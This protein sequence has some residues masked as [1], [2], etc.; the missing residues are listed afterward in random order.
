[1]RGLTQFIGDI[2]N[3][4]NKEDERKR[5]DKEMANI[6]KHFKEATKLTPY[7]KKKYVWKMLY[8]YVLG[9]EVDFGHMEALNLITAPGYSEKTVGYLACV[10]LLSET[11]EF[12]RLII[13]ST[14]N[15]LMSANEEIQGLSLACVA[16]VG[17]REFA[18]TLTVDV[19]K[20]LFNP[21][22]R[23]QVK[24]KAALCMLRLLRKYPDNFAEDGIGGNQEQKDKL[25]DLL[26]DSSLGVITATMSLLLG[27]VSHNPELWPDSVNKCCKLLAK[28]NHPNASKEYGPEYVYYKTINPWL[29]VKVLRLLQYYPPPEREEVNKR[30]CEVLQRIISETSM[31]KNVNTN[32]SAHAVVFEAVN[33]VIH[34]ETNQQLIHA[35]VNMLGQRITSGNQPNYRY[36]ALDAMQRMSHIPEAAQQFKRHQET[37]IRSLKDN[38]VSLRRRSLDVLYSMCDSNNSEQVVGELLD[39]LAGSDFSIREE[40]VLRVAILAE[41]FSPNL[42]WYV[43]TILKLMSL[44]G[45]YVS[46]QVWMRVVQIVTNH[47]D[48][49]LYAAETCFK[50]LKNEAVHESMVKCGGYI[51]GEF[52]HHIASK[53]E[54]SAEEQ[55][56]LLKDKFDS[57][58]QNET[59]QLLLTAFI[60]LV[61]VHPDKV[62]ERVVALLNHHT[63]TIDA[64]LQQRAIEYLVLSR[65]DKESMLETV[66][67]VMPNFPER[68]NILTKKI[69][70][71]ERASTT[72]RTANQIKAGKGGEDDDEDAPT[73]DLSARGK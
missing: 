63:H 38:D 1:M 58:D 50:A 34:M 32:N 8:I 68:E 3:C 31:G 73:V 21:Q 25:L 6:R 16:N 43:D 69:K 14:K 20:L 66:L 18:E 15:D 47:E 46:D 62:K 56:A 67:D 61:N 19:Q 10:L 12:L 7:Q 13:N 26:D 17:G 52:G 23:P 65:P 54:T 35:A 72:D 51:L 2:R 37:I 36:L 64:E 48:L 4:A 28:L 70:E 59:K 11:N 53:R 24:K 27:L 30:L 44:A 29:Q 42:Q 39:Y 45:D 41:R 49:Q 71:R 60:K 55:F 5:V 57:C 22:A 33:Y 40:L 9:Y